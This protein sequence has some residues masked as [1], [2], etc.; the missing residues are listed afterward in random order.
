[1]AST[2]MESAVPL[3]FSHIPPGSPAWMSIAVIAALVLHI[4]GGGV[5][6]LAGYGAVIAPKGGRWHRWFGTTFAIAMFVM[7]TMAV[8]L[9]VLIQQ[10]GNVA[11]G[12]LA[13]YLVATAWMAV[14]RRDGRVGVFEK[15]ACAVAASTGVLLVLWGL[16]ARA[17]HV[18]DDPAL[19][20]FIFAGFSALFAA[21]DL[22]MIARGGTV[23]VQRIARHLWRMSA[24][25][26]FA[27]G[28]FFIGQQKV[29]PAAWHG[30]PV[31]FV[32]GLAP[33]AF[34]I[35]WMLRVRFAKAFRH[36]ATA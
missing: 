31:L 1:M 27:A 8:G 15:L 5:A 35:F 18:A 19:P 22:G 23:G 13:A 6:I 36:A 11:G 26:F 21:L 29:M 25:F 10:R 20:Y 7:A 33:L 16:Q 24:A 34:L 4:G 2:A 9:A 12:I 30:S 3:S 14:K 32:L 17:A 28:S